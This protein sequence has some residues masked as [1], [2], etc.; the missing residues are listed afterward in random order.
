MT[1]DYSSIPNIQF[2]DIESFITNHPKIG[3]V[4]MVQLS[5]HDTKGRRYYRPPQVFM[6]VRG[7]Y[8]LWVITKKGYTHLFTVNAYKKVVYLGNRKI[9]V[10]ENNETTTMKALVK[11]QQ[12]LSITSW[13]SV[14]LIV[15]KIGETTKTSKAY[16]LYDGLLKHKNM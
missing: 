11:I 10:I 12:D 15:D 13:Q 4:K 1:D 14:H 3:L 16:E 7:I 5:R 6:L 2:R 8:L 9:K